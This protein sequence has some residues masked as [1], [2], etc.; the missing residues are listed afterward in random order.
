MARRISGGNMLCRRLWQKAHT[1]ITD[2]IVVQISFI[3]VSLFAKQ[4]KAEM[5]NLQGMKKKKK[6]RGFCGIL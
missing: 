1:P 6:K 4:R 2:A 3:F 5:L